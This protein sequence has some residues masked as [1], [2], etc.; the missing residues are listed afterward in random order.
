MRGRSENALLAIDA[1]V[2]ILLGLLLLT[3]PANIVETLGL[4]KTDNTFYPG[5]LG[6]VLI[7]IGAALLL[8]R[9]SSTARGKGLG[10]GGAV[11]IN[12]CGGLALAGWLV[13]GGLEVPARGHIVLWALVA[14]H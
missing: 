7:G 8:E 2:N 4:P 3:Y 14:V 11:V 13:L 6:A 10:L 9:F 5:I 12:L 1:A